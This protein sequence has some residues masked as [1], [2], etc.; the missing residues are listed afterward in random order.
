MADLDES[1]ARLAADALGGR[2]G[3][4]EFGV[5]GLKVFELLHQLVEI[6]IA[7]L[8]LIEDVIE[9]FVVANLFAESFDLL[10]GVF[11]GRH[12]RKL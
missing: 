8:G 2:I 6:Q 5:L 11:W 4:D 10:F 1:L 7:D 3:R 12:R 9:I